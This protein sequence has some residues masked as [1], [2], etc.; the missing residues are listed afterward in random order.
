MIGLYERVGLL[1]SIATI[2]TLSTPPPRMSLLLPSPPRMPLL[3]VLRDP[4]PWTVTA[5]GPVGPQAQ[6]MSSL[7]A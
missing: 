5:N 4:D 2:I 7:P 1:G 3:L 6:R